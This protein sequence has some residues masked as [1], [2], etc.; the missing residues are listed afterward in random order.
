MI[1]PVLNC[2]LIQRPRSSR[3][4]IEMMMLWYINALRMIDA[5]RGCGIKQA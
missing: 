3:Q 2:K 1:H 4:P 5:P